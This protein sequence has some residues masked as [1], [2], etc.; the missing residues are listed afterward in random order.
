[1]VA[2]PTANEILRQHLAKLGKK[3]GIARAKAL[4]E[5]QRAASARKEFQRIY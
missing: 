1:M 2:M 3:G 5:E 4:N